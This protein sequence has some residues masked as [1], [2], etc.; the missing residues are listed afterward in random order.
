MGLITQSVN[1]AHQVVPLGHNCFQQPLV[2]KKDAELR[3]FQAFTVPPVSIQDFKGRTYDEI[4]WEAVLRNL[5]ADQ[6]RTHRDAILLDASKLAALKIDLSYSLFGKLH[7]QG[8]TSFHQGVFLG[9][10]RIEVGDTLRV[11]PKSFHTDGIVYFSLGE[12][13]SEELPTGRAVSFGGTCYQLHEGVSNQLAPISDDE[14]PRAL[15]DESIWRKS[16]GPGQPLSWGRLDGYVWLT[17]AEVRGRFYPTH[18]LAPIQDPVKFEEAV[19]MGNRTAVTPAL[20]GR[21]DSAVVGTKHI[22]W[23]LNRMVTAGGAIPHNTVFRFEPQVKEDLG[24]Q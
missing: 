17:E 10:E 23:R 8:S 16:V 21:L 9:A 3:P 1:G 13:K 20:N 7:Q 11:T 4:P 15:R 19:R 18:L 2:A 6:S 22:G 12:I 24:G 5:T 14:L